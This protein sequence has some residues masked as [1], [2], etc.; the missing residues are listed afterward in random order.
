MILSLAHR[1]NITKKVLNYF[2]E[3]FLRLWVR[4]LI[5]GISWV[6]SIKF[7]VSSLKLI[8]LYYSSRRSITS[9]LNLK[10]STLVS[11]ILTLSLLSLILVILNN[12]EETS[13]FPIAVITLNWNKILM[14]N[15]RSGFK[16]CIPIAGTKYLMLVNL[17]TWSKIY[18]FSFSYCHVMI[19]IIS[20]VISNP[21][22]ISRPCIQ[23]PI[24]NLR[25]FFPYGRWWICYQVKYISPTIGLQ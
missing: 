8:F 21:F 2:I 9:H 4:N 14:V 15:V 16:K 10:I 19:D 7:G 17:L 12:T 5:L 1:S 23:V 20:L 11:R 13:R 6:S 3:I 22:L 24:L 25:T 18:L